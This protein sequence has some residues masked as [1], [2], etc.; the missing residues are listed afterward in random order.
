MIDIIKNKYNELYGTESTI[1]R[2]PGRIN[3]LGEHTDYN[4]GFVL[5]ASIDKEM[6]FA[7]GKNGTKTTCNLYAYDLLESYT[8]DLKEMSPGNTSWSN[9]IKGVIAEIYKN[10]KTIEGF[11][12]V[13][14]GNIPL[15]AGLSSSAALE[16]GTATALNELFSL[17]FEKVELVKMAQM[18]EHNYAGV[19]CGIMDQFASIMGKEKS[20]FKLDCRTLDFDY[21]PLELENYQIILCDTQVKHSLASSEYNTRRQECEKGVEI[22][23]EENPGI[24]NLRDVSIDLM[25][26]FKGKMPEKIF[27]RCSYVVEENDRVLKASKA[28]SDHNIEL[29]G[30]LMYETHEGLRRKYEVSCEEL[31]F[32]VDLTKNLDYVA[33]SRMMGGGFGG[34]TINLVKRGHIGAFEDLISKKYH[35]EFN[36]E[37]AIYEVEITNGAE[38]I[39]KLKHE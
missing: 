13:F 9:Y 38:E 15:G 34:C 10:G 32:L 17:G 25:N 30:K 20:A 23:K 36:S 6:I 5:P 21:F 33:G 3:L 16:S 8:F 14:G 1:F 35:E 4:D 37:A 11:D 7:I 18:A 2:A 12:M 26:S 19:M 24:I 27:D 28:L 22:I 39:K 29:T 31:D